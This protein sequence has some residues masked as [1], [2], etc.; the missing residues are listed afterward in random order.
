M[1]DQPEPIG[2]ADPDDGVDETPV[3]PE[4]QPEPEPEPEPEQ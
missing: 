3:E 1:S 4:P 2:D